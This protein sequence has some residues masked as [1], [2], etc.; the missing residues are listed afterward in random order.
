MS[1]SVE[2]DLQEVKQRLVDS[3]QMIPAVDDLRQFLKLSREAKVRNPEDVGKYGSL[4]L[5]HYR[6]KLD[7][8]EAWLLH[9]QVSIALMECGNPAAALPFV[10]AV[11]LKFDQDSIRARRLQGLYYEAVGKPDRAQELYRATITQQP[12]ISILPKRLAALHRS[13]GELPEAIDVLKHYLDHWS[14]DK[15][16]WEELADCY[17]EACQYQQAAFCL[18]EVLSTG[19]LSPLVL[20]KYA[21]VLATLGSPSQLKA[22][23]AYYSQALRVSGG[24]SVRALYGII[25]VGKQLSPKDAASSGDAAQELPAVCA[26]TLLKMYQ[27]QGPEHLQKVVQQ[28]LKQ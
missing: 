9:E 26:Q 2:D 27:Q 28:T 15:D 23:R 12:W 3:K 24:R 19:P 14:N 25:Y 1:G 8:D 13:Q 11:M 22:A 17:L 18:E 16:A 20:I 7:E 5:Q 4:L 6:N 10:K 21:D